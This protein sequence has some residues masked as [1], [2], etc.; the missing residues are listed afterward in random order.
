MIISPGSLTDGNYTSRNYQK[1][2]NDDENLEIRISPRAF[3]PLDNKVDKNHYLATLIHEILHAFS[4]A[5]K[6]KREAFENASY[7]RHSVAEGIVQNTTLEVMQYLHRSDEEIKP[8]IGFFYDDRVVTAS[9]L[10]AILRFGGKPETISAW[11]GFLFEDGQLLE[12]LRQA[13]KNLNLDETIA[14]DIA[15][16]NG[17]LK[18]YPGPTPQEQLLVKLL[19]KLR[20]GGVNLSADFIKS[21][22]TANRIYGDYGSANI[23]DINV[24]TSK[25]FQQMLE[26]EKNSKKN[27]K[28]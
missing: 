23:R 17:D 27:I 14:D 20:L 15:A 28:K 21:I 19:A 26:L 1:N 18:L 8:A 9:I 5:V 13:L 6:N 10:R 4:T 3:A 11:H 7:L 24:E 22:L 16:L 12:D 25:W 2:A